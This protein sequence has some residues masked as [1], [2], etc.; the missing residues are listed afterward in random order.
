MTL[1]SRRPHC[2]AGASPPKQR[3]RRVHTREEGGARE[4]EGACW[5][6]NSA[7]RTQRNGPPPPSRHVALR[8]ATL[9]TANP[10]CSC[11]LMCMLCHCTAAIHHLVINRSRQRRCDGGVAKRR[12]SSTPPPH[13]RPTSNTPSPQHRP[14]STSHPALRKALLERAAALSRGAAGPARL[15]LSVTAEEVRH[16]S[17]GDLRR[18]PELA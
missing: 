12:R 17:S 10:F 4:R 5:R 18:L 1:R 6:I 3:S 2:Q 14:R 9:S 16:A 8:R 13:A 15:A 7:E 11:V